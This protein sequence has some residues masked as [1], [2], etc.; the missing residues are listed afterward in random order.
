MG[1]L[2]DIGINRQ[3]PVVEMPPLVFFDTKKQ[4]TRLVVTP[5]GCIIELEEKETGEVRKFEVIGTDVVINPEYKERTGLV[6]IGN[7]KDWLYS[8]R[9]FL[10]TKDLE[11]QIRYRLLTAVQ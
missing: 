8:K 2:A 10:D 9:R 11:K 5:S 1:T 4:Q 7:R 3:V 6:D